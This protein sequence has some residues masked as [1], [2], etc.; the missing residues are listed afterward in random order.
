MAQELRLAARRLVRA[1]AFTLATISTLA[2]ALGANTAIFAVVQRVVLNPLP[3]G[4]SDRLIA[5]RYAIPSRNV[6]AVYTFPSRFYYEYLERART[7]DGLAFYWPATGPG[8]LTL[9]GRGEP[10]RIRFISATPSLLSV[11]RVSPAHG[12]WFTESEGAPGAPPVAVLSHGLWQRRYGENP[13]VIGSVVTLDGVAT[14]V[15]GIMAPTFRFP[16]PRVDVWT[17]ATLSRA[18]ATDTYQFAGVARLG[19]GATI[20]RARAELTELTA[21]LEAA[22]PNNGYK[23]LTSTALTLL[24]A[25]V[26]EVSRTLWVLL[27]SVG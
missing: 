17:P 20:E 19:S 10:E 24:D 25:T 22:H 4:D 15:V 16:D 6:P 8:E 3:Y 18:T 27:A 11:L 26:G 1:P 9:T 21:A 23:V 7:L 13:A 12:R 5:L 2:L 14:T